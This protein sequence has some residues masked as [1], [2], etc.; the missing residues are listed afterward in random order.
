MIFF[1]TI[2][3]YFVDNTAKKSYNNAITLKHDTRGMRMKYQYYSDTPTFT[4]ENVDIQTVIRD[5]NY[6]HAFKSGRYKHGFILTVEKSIRYDLSNGAS[7]RAESGELVF[8]PKGYV[9]SCTYLEDKTKIKIIQ[10]DLAGG[11]LPDYLTSPIKISLPDTAEQIRPFFSFAEN[12]LSSHPFYYLSCVYNLLWH[13]DES[14][15]HIPAKYVKLQPAISA[16]SER[17]E[18]NRPIS[19]YAELCDMSEVNFRRQF[20]KY[21]GKSPI[22]YRNDIRLSKAKIKLQSG[23]FNVAETAYLCGFSNLSFFIR[24][25]KKRYGHTPKKE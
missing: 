13:I 22:E 19:Y 24:L 7:I 21:I 15:S 14:H 4:V 23:E 16:L 2:R 17:C 6:T 5:K 10:F 25:Y 18:E 1:N 9:Y 3:S 20:G 11:A 12:R 8:I